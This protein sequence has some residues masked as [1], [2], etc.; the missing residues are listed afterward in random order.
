MNLILGKRM[1]DSEVLAM[2]DKLPELILDARCDTPLPAERAI[3]AFDA[4]S[5]SLN[6]EEHIGLITALGMTHEKALRELEFARLVTSRGYLEE[7][8]KRELP[9]LEPE[10]V[11]YGETK[12]IRQTRAPLGVL[13]HIAAGNV[14]ALPVFSVLEG[15]LTGNVNVLK[16][17]RDDGGLSVS[18]FERLFEIEPA[19]RKRVFVFD[20]PSENVSILEGLAEVSDAVVVWGGD[21][22]VSAVRRLAKPDTCVIEWGHRISFAY[23]SG[24]APDRELVGVCRNICATEQLLCSSCQGVFLDSSDEE[25]LSAFAERFAELLGRTAL[26]MPSYH[27]SFLRAQKSIELYTEELEAHENLVRIIKKR[28]CSVTVRRDSALEPSIMFRDPWVKPLPRAALVRTLSKYKNRLQTA[29][30]I[31][32][33]NDRAELEELLVRAGTVRVTSGERM[34]ETFA[35]APHDGGSPLLRYTKHVTFEY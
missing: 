14:D 33:E 27:G 16:L 17:P 10:F 7:R 21:E 20:F 26:E 3:A 11:P 13:L 2:R 24:E 18:I 34:S 35:G 19:L 6:E 32:G 25:E 8:L 30:L 29:A 4:L 9:P 15:L 22:A 12:P 5:R 28:G 31:C 1:N 23:V